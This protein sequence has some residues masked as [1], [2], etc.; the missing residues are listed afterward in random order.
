MIRHVSPDRLHSNAAEPQWFRRRSGAVILE[1]LLVFPIVLVVTLAIFQF[2]IL[3]LV[4]HSGTAAL[5]DGTQAGAAVFPDGFL[6]DAPGADDDIADVVA[7]V[8]GSRLMIFNTQV[9]GNYEIHITRGNEGPFERGDGVAGYDPVPLVPVP[10]AIQVRLC[11][12]LVGPVPDWLSTFGFSLTN[13][14]FEMTSLATL[15]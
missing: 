1:F 10:G 3:A 13:G 8:I 2:G 15:E 9:A 12:P 11:F 14:R 4:V 6:V 5:L 7:S